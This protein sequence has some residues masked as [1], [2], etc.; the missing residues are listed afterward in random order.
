MIPKTATREEV[1]IYHLHID[2]SFARQD[3]NCLLPLDRLDELEEAGEIGRSASRHYSF[4]GYI[5]DPADLLQDST[6]AIIQHLRE[7]QVDVVLLVPT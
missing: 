6:P 4:M 2:P 7:D 5:L 3:L 1:E